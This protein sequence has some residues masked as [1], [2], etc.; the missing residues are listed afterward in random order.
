MARKTMKMEKR[1]VVMT[2][3]EVLFYEERAREE[4]RR[5]S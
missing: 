4:K 2:P 5:Q 1:K 3:E